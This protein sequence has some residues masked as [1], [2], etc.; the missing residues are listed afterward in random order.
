[1][2]CM[3]L[4]DACLLRSLRSTT[5]LFSCKLPSF[6][7]D[8]E[9]LQRSKLSIS[10]GCTA[11]KEDMQTSSETVVVAERLSRR[12]IVCIAYLMGKTR[13]CKD[14][15]TAYGDFEASK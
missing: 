8:E 14:K 10:T 12:A 4:E 15:K 2:G 13:G 7:S 5:E 6:S 1:M 3:H 11:D 9:P